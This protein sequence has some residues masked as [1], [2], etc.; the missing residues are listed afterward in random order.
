MI[1]I[2]QKVNGEKGRFLIYEDDTLAGEMTYVCPEARGEDYSV[3]SLCCQ[4]VCP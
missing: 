1:Q 2:E 4:G 3:V